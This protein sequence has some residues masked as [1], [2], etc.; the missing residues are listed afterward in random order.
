MITLEHTLIILLLLVGLINAQPKIPRLGWWAI[1][2]ALG[3]ALIAP[4]APLALPWEWLSALLIP[5]LLW[6]AG[7][8]LARVQ[9][10]VKPKEVI[11]WLVIALGIGGIVLLTSGLTIAGSLMFGLLTA[12]M[13]WRA[14]QQEQHTSLLG[15]A[16]PL[17]LAFL[18]AEI[19]PLVEAPGRYAV[20]LIAGAGI[21][22]LVSY[23]AVQIAQKVTSRQ[24]RD[25]LSVGQVYAAY[26]LAVGFNLSG[27]AAA[28]MSVAVYIAYG[29][30]CGL[31]SDGTIHPKPLDSK[32]VFILAV[33]ALAF[34][35]W[36]THVPLRS[37]LLL[38]IFL[39]LT[40]TALV[41]WAGR[42]L[43]SDPFLLEPSFTR[44]MLRVGAL[45]VPAILL[46]PREAL[47][48]PLPLVIAV[49]TALATIIGTRYTLTPLL[50][51]YAWLDET[52]RVAASPGELS[53]ALLVRDFMDRN[54]LTISIDTPVP[55]IA[56]LL[57]TSGA[58]SLPV[59]DAEGKLA[60]IVT[61]H[62]LFV[63]EEK[64]PNTDRTYPAVFKE[65]TSPEQL[66]K[67]YAQL[68]SNYTAAKV[69]SPR[70]VWVKETTPLGQAIRLMVRYGFR[71]LPVLDA[72]PESGGK[73]VGIL[74][75]ESIVRL[76]AQVSD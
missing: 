42:Q 40:F 35:A 59:L 20:A 63:T 61:E 62:D 5:L 47:L 19:A 36:Q 9:L 69:M 51:I 50:N 14:T 33:L 58:V 68:G 13:A 73:L 41:I 56:R 1:V 43:K 11:I 39:A 24:R 52:E 55:E 30:R 28:L 17:A 26:A 70:V 18:L 60:G 4:A 54:Y 53:Q 6:Q 57:T 34:F 67:V 44:I 71:S 38:E 15:Q 74:T 3:L 31:W 23:I 27:V 66:P 75:R 76:L 32:Q 25:I 64:L 48:D 29:A 45:L 49:A 22:A 12:S 72:A 7:G 21:G 65:P 37:I 46:W 10:S 8:Q 16:S 2:V